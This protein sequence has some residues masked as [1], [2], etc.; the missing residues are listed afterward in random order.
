MIYSR[1]A[2][3]GSHLP[4]R[5]MTNKDLEQFMDTSDEWIRDRTGIRER[6]VIGPGETT[7][8]LALAACRKAMEAAQVEPAEID[9]FVLGTTTPNLVFPS[10]AC[11]IHKDLGLVDC[12]AMDVNAACSGF[13]Y[14]LSIADKYIRCGDA[15]K[16]LVAGAETLTQLINWNKRDTAVLFGDGAGAVVLEASEEP[17]ILSTHIHADGRY[18]DLLRTDVGPSVGFAGIEN[19]D[20]KPEISMRGNEV[21]KVAVR[22]L[23]RMVDETLSANNI[24]KSELDWLLPHQANYRIIT[25]TAKMLD[26]DMDQVIVTVDRHGNTSAASVPLA[27]DEAVRDGRLQRGQLMLLEAFGG[28]FTWG[29]ALIRY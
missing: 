10:T 17:G 19:N 1:I 27:L 2:G 12:G 29:S 24:D 9:L 23:H 14:A 20:G 15:R 8:T 25:A 5:V 28:G 3:T 6:R 21:F 22:T 26:M 7:G 16:V 11:L 13:M 4:E 18:A